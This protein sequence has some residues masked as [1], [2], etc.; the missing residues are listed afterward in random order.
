MVK[1]KKRFD[2]TKR[3]KKKKYQKKDILRLFV[4]SPSNKENPI[5]KTIESCMLKKRK[6]ILHSKFY[7]LYA[8]VRDRNRETNRNRGTKVEQ[9]S[10]IP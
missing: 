3:N 8:R 5:P 4:D 6:L 7:C 1:K 2:Q 10:G 9:N